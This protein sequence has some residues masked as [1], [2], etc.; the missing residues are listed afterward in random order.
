VASEDDD[1]GAAISRWAELS[2][3]KL[4]AIGDVE[5]AIL[6]NHLVLEDV[7]KCVLAK[8][9]RLAEHAFADLRTGFPTL[10]EIAMAGV[11]KP[12]LA[13]ALRALNG[14][15]NLVSH[16]VESPEVSGKMAIFMQE[17]GRQLGVS[18]TWPDGRDAQLAALARASGEAAV[19]LFQV[20]LG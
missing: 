15:R 16:R 10:L 3:E 13:S 11:D 2:T 4:A 1:T 17:V 20:A 19:E 18:M 9:L 6:K 7:L 12:H 8:R 14:A 5:L